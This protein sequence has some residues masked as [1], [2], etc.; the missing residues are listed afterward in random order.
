MKVGIS[1]IYQRVDESALDPGTIAKV[2]AS[3]PLFSVGDYHR[4]LERLARN[5]LN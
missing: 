5:A 1:M 4:K 2:S 3:E